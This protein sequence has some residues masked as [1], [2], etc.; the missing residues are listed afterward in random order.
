MSRAWTEDK[1]EH[2]VPIGRFKGFDLFFCPS[3][4][5]DDEG[6]RV[7]VA[8]EQGERTYPSVS[9]AKA[10]INTA[11]RKAAKRVFPRRRV[12]WIERVQTPSF[13][14]HAGAYEVRHGYFTG[15]DAKDGKPMF[16]REEGEEAV[17]R[18]RIHEVYAYVPG[19][20]ES[21]LAEIAATMTEKLRASQAVDQAEEK[22]PH[23]YE[24]GQQKHDRC[25]CSLS[26]TDRGL[27]GARVGTHGAI[28][29]DEK[30]LKE[31][32]AWEDCYRDHL[33]GKARGR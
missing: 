19:F 12:C 11:L 33:D 30:A 5:Q 26:N 20:T 15:H 22:R 1:I 29:L 8:F 18:E 2:R 13:S 17:P 27:R 14:R 31:I 24:D 6:D 32:G 23:R 10:G 28:E 3:W 25:V 16:V 9:Q 7:V 4:R 21:F